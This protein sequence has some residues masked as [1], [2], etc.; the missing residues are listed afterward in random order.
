LAISAIAYLLARQRGRRVYE[1]RAAFSIFALSELMAFVL[2]YLF[3]Q[4]KFAPPLFAFSAG[5]GL[6]VWRAS[7]DAALLRAWLLGGAWREMRLTQLR[8]E[9]VIDGIL[10][11]GLAYQLGLSLVPA[12]LLEWA[13]PGHGWN[14]LGLLLLGSMFLSLIFLTSQ[15]QRLVP[16]VRLTARQ[17]ALLGGASGVY[18]LMLGPQSWKVFWLAQLGLLLVALRTLASTALEAVPEG[19]G[20]PQARATRKRSLTWI[21]ESD[22]AIVARERARESARLGRGNWSAWLYFAGW[23]LGL[24][25]LPPLALYTSYDPYSAGWS[26]WIKTLGTHALAGY[27]LLVGVLQ[28]M[29]SHSRVFQA[30]SE[31]RDRQTLDLLVV[32]SLDGQDFVDGW[33]EVGY[34]TRQLEMLL[35]TLSTLA[36]A[37]MW[38]PP[39][40]SL[41]LIAYTGLLGL[42]LCVAGAYSGLLLGFRHCARVKRRRHLLYP[43]SLGSW[44]LLTLPLA[45]WGL[46]YLLMQAGALYLVVQYSRRQA[47]ACLG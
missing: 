20:L 28:A 16:Q 38:G 34:S 29:R 1:V 37:Y 17:V 26:L 45:S 39:L 46:L 11:Q 13:W 44:A 43:L 3:G 18:A 4:A 2:A 10:L 23:G 5:F 12:L 8:S 47:L 31:E 33:A 27:L 6:A 24:S 32:T 14:W 42:A 9:T 19:E 15:L 36:C 22:N 41:A 40:E 21:S 30:L 25:L 7:S 35:V